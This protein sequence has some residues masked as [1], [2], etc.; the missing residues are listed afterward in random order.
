MNYINKNLAKSTIDKKAQ[1]TSLKQLVLGTAGLGGIWGDINKEES[2]DTILLA[3]ESGIENIDTA[4]AYSDAEEITGMALRQWRGKAPVVST[5]VGRLKSNKPDIALYGYSPENIKKSAYSSIEKLGIGYVDVLFLHDPHGIQNY[6]VDNCIN[7]LLKLKE[8]GIVKRLG[9]GGNY[10]SSFEKNISKEVFDVYMGYNR[11]NIVSQDAL[12]N[13]I[14]YLKEQKIQIWQ[15]SPLY[16]GLLGRDFEKYQQSPPEW[17]PPLHLKRACEIKYYSDSI[18]MELSEI[19][20]RY[21]RNI[22]DI[23]KVVIGS[24]N[25]KELLNSLQNW[26]KGTLPENILNHINQL[27]IK[28]NDKN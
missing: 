12:I 13:E 14:L 17:I 22:S 20:L 10:P 24:S 2:V 21:L 5:K 18:K 8:E 6:E 4:P 26:R 9:I 3:L 7:A 19:S 16:M 15:A 11:L 1:K 27:N 25:K 28:S 23:D